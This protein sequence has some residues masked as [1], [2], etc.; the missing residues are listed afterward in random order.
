MDACLPN[1]EIIKKMSFISY[2]QNN[3][4][5]M[6]WR[7]FKNITNG[8][9]IDVG[10]NDP[11]ED[12]VTKAFYDRGWHGI[13]IE[14]VQS[15]YQDLKNERS[16]DINLL[17]AAGL[18]NGE[19]DIW[20]CEVRG[21]ATASPSVVAMHEAN[22]H[23]GTYQKVPVY[24]LRD[25]CEQHVHGEIHFLKID[26][27][28][29]EKEVID[30]MD[31]TKYRPWVLVVEATKPNSNK[32]VFDQWEGTLLAAHYT[33]AYS[34]GINRFYLANER[35]EYLEFLSYP[36][37][38]FDDYIRIQ[39]H[40]LEIK[41]QQAEDKAYEA[42][43]IANQMKLRVAQAYSMASDAEM[44]AK[45]FKTA[46]DD[47]MA[48]LNAVYSSTSWRMLKPLRSIKTRV[49]LIVKSILKI[50]IRSAKSLANKVPAVK[51]FGIRFLRNHPRLLRLIVNHSETPL[52]PSKIN[53]EL[54]ESF[55]SLRSV[56]M[57]RSAANLDMK[58]AGESVVILEVERSDK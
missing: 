48:Q 10:A 23:I 27:E 14:P 12:S 35:K 53:G 54:I 47:A 57:I 24:P 22:G 40:R 26:V 7:A 58:D 3:E 55:K 8:F 36:P 32:A 9:Y 38:I 29:L 51:S 4:D 19:I 16:R 52:S 17:C 49:V 25:I 31:F 50:A 43:A 42:Q 13:N 1:I 30:G 21:W 39:Q 28:G 18:S 15:H 44:R 20:E 46:L 45:Q 34:D 33:Y 56:R 37:N 11:E 41:A 2:A 5:V 6:L